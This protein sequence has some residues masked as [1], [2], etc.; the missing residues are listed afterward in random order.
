M[1]NDRFPRTL[2][3]HGWQQNIA[4]KEAMQSHV[5]IG[6]DDPMMRSWCRARRTAAA[7]QPSLAASAST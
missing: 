3:A 2:V 7:R 6:P 1:L 4:P 5:L